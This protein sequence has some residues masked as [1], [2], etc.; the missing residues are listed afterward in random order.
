MSYALK[1]EVIN[2]SVYANDGT[3]NSSMFWSATKTVSNKDSD[4]SSVNL[5]PTII[6][7]KSN[8]TANITVAAILSRSERAT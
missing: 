7:K 8:V 5:T 2:V 1:G 4:V 6:R 3:D